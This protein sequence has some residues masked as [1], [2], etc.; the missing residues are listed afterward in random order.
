MSVLQQ[1][2]GKKG[3]R[4]ILRQM[5]TTSG[6]IVSQGF[7]QET[8]TRHFFSAAKLKLQEQQMGKCFAEVDKTL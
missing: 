3:Q 6:N 7:P 1:L 4:F 5:C 2:D 8:Q